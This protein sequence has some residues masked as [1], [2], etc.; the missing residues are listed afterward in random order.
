[1]IVSGF[2]CDNAGLIPLTVEL[3]TDST[4]PRSE[5]HG[6]V[7]DRK[8]QGFIISGESGAGKTE[9][10]KIATRLEGRWVW[11]PDPG[12]LQQS[13]EHR[14]GPSPCL[15]CIFQ[16]H[17]LFCFQGHGVLGL[18]LRVNQPNDCDWAI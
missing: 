16:G 4:C 6:Q 7:R 17:F 2:T 13:V 1:M 3:P 15:A 18:R 9:T 10:A 14:G 11:A 12:S 5:T 8:N